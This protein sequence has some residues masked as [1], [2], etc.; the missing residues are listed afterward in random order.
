MIENS[1]VAGFRT[2]LRQTPPAQRSGA[3][4]HRWFHEERGFVA[5]GVARGAYDG[6]RKRRLALDQEAEPIE[7]KRE[8]YSALEAELAG[9][10][11]EGREKVRA[12]VERIMAGL[13][14]EHSAAIER[15]QGKSKLRDY[16]RARGLGDHDITKV[17]RM[18]ERLGVDMKLAERGFVTGE[19]WAL[20]AV[21]RLDRH[22][23]D[24]LLSRIVGCR[25]GERIHTTTAEEDRGFQS[26]YPGIPA[27][28]HR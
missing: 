11:P 28:R 6:K 22:S 10:S 25:P 15:E 8:G 19:R 18:A 26:R 24:I 3:A 21:A 7:A 13:S 16:L 4:F 17:E 20:D 5:R 27:V 9:L 2:W 12:A 1:I 23:A 14:R